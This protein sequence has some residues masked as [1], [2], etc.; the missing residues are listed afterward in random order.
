MWLLSP[1]WHMI[2]W[3]IGLVLWVP[4][5]FLCIYLDL[6]SYHKSTWFAGGWSAAVFLLNMTPSRGEKFLDQ[7]FIS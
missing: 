4:V 3:G 7:R 6:H 2:L 5:I 1:K